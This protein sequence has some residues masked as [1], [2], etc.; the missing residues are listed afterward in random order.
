[1]AKK[2][3]TKKKKKI[4]PLVQTVVSPVYIPPDAPVKKTSSNDFNRP[5]ELLDEVERLVRGNANYKRNQPLMQ[6]LQQYRVQKLAIK[7]WNER[8]ARRLT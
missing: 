5:I 8:I 1:M 4:I 6:I 3:V 2:K 7:D